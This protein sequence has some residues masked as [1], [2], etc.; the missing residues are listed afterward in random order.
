MIRYYVLFE[1]SEQGWALHRLLDEAGV[2]NR[3]VPAPAAARG[4]LS[5]GMAILVRPEE[6]DAARAVIRDSGAAHHGIVP[7]EDP[8]HARRDRYC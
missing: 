8:L 1:N 5:C 4:E 3:I 6:I 7:L 2:M